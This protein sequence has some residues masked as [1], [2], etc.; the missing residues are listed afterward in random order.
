MLFA[1]FS[2]DFRPFEYNVQSG[3]EGFLHFYIPTA[4]QAFSPRLQSTNKQYD[5]EYATVDRHYEPL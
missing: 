3:L 5:T 2:L 4:H 1:K